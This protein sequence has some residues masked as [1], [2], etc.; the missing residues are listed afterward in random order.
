VKEVWPLLRPS[1]PGAS[2]LRPMMQNLSVH[3]GQ[4]CAGL[5]EPEA[6]A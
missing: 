3:V 1:W 2:P 4:T 6:K 5:S